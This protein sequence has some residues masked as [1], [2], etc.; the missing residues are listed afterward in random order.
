MLNRYGRDLT[1]LAQEGQLNPVIGRENEIRTMAQ[2]LLRRTKNN[3]L[4]VGEA[5]VGKTCLVEGLAQRLVQ[6]KVAE[7]LKD[8]RIVELSLSSVVA[9]TRYRGDFEERLE[10]ILAEARDHPEVV[11]FLDEIHTLV[12]AGSASGMVMDAANILKP[13]LARGELTCIGAT[14]MDEYRRYIERDAALERRFE[15]V[16]VREPSAEETHQILTGLRPSYE[17][18]HNLKIAD[19]A[20]AAAVKLAERYIR[21]RH[22][23][24]KA[25]DLID[26]ACSQV[27]LQTVSGT[28]GGQVRAKDVAQVVAQRTGIPVESLSR[29]EAQVLLALEDALRKRVMGQEEAVAAVAETVRAYRSGLRNPRRPSGVFLFL[30]PTGV[31][32]TELVRALA[33]ELFGSEDKLLRFDMSEYMERHTVSRLIGSPPGYVRSDEEGQLTGAVRTNPYSIVLFDELE[34]AHPE[35]LDLFLQIF[36]AGRLTDSQGHVVD[37]SNTIIVMTS[38]VGSAVSSASVG[39]R[40]HEISEPRDAYVA[41]VQRAVR[42]TFRPEFINRIDEMV[43]FNPLDRETL[44]QIAAKFLEEVRGYLAERNLD[45]IVLD[46]VYD[47]L[48][49]EGYNEAYGARE[50]QRAVD[51]LITKPMA[52]VLLEQHVQSGEAV[53]VGVADRRVTFERQ[54]GPRT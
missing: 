10:K 15:V 11:L 24:D 40:V 16:Q 27:K 31:G 26:T 54:P 8:R 7:A 44:R 41:R 3:P 28:Q 13:A 18:H 53:R 23:P 51:R 25:I 6:E 29:E 46:E 48:I 36:D 33:A 30:G 42:E 39:F 52:R 43:I 9:G 2:I 47:L 50:M 34:K 35:V 22:F 17:D 1:L 20:L 45:L 49:V 4:L 37:F 32:K 19:E 14:T 12:G 21:T 5:G 38:N